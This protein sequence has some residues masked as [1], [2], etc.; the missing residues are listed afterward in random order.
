MVV[1]V[2]QGGF[3]PPLGT[4]GR[5]WKRFWLSRLRSVLVEPRD[6]ANQDGPHTREYLAPDTGKCRGEEALVN[7]GS[8]S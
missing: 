5:V 7:D 1:A 2:N 4:C 8:V 6:A 3:C